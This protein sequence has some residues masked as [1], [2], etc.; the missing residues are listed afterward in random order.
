M[1]ESFAYRALSLSARKV[2][3]RLEI[4]FAHHG[5]ENGGQNGKLIATYDDFE[6]YGMDRHAI[7]PA[8]NEVIALGFVEIKEQGCAGNER[9]RRP[10]KFRL[11]YRHSAKD[12]PT[13]DWR[14]VTSKKQAQELAAEARKRRRENRSPMGKKPKS[15]WRKP[16]L[17]NNSPLRGTPIMA[18]VE[19]S[20]LLSISRIGDAVGYGVFEGEERSQPEPRSP[21]GRATGSSQQ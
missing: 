19:E 18:I 9:Y 3:D 1:L 6:A 20:P 14:R 8:I 13:H 11:T 12:H 21:M 10:N 5:G 7:G 4:E 15:E 2:L 16:T 17:E